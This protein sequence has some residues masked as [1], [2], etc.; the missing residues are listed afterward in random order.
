MT[1]IWKFCFLELRK[2]YSEIYFLNKN[3]EIDFFIPEESKYIQVVYDLTFENL[4]RETRNL[5]KQEWEKI[6][7]Y[8]NKEEWIVVDE[9]V[10]LMD[11][12]EFI[13]K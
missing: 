2:Q 9:K 11:F 8:F 13:I 4:E 7:I 1:K 12:S 6:L 5:L 10:K 3:Y